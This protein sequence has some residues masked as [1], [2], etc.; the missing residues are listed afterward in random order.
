MDDR[1]IA[2]SHLVIDDLL[3]EYRIG[4]SGSSAISELSLDRRYPDIPMSR[5]LDIS[6]ELTRYPDPQSPDYL[7]RSPDQ[8]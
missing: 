2:P 3:S 8:P 1:A 6:I 5:Y 7:A 4:L